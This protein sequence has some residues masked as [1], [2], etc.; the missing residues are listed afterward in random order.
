LRAE[1][2]RQRTE[3]EDLRRQ[4]RIL[5]ELVEE[6]GR[7]LPSP[8]PQRVSRRDVLK[9]GVVG[10]AAIAGAVVPSTGRSSAAG[11]QYL[12]V[13]A[14]V[15]TAHGPQN[16]AP[17]GFVVDPSAE[18]TTGV[19]AA[20]T[21][22]GVAGAAIDVKGQLGGGTGVQGQSQTGFGV[23]GTSTSA[24]GVFGSSQTK[25]GVHGSSQKSE[26]VFGQTLHG[27]RAVTG[28]NWGNAGDGVHG[29]SRQQKGRQ[30]GKGNGVFGQSGSGNGVVGKSGGGTGIRG[31]SGSGRGGVFQ[32][33]T[34]AVNL[35]PTKYSGHP[36]SGTH[37]KGDLMVDRNGD[38]YICSANGK[39]GRWK[40][41]VVK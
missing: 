20:G 35:Q 38:L 3:I 31:S 6:N 19:N 11:S 40:R 13:D 12:P 14:S 39:P 37:W 1:M 2:R 22:V 28:I 7:E 10:V 41:V 8:S 25:Y 21:Q 29:E 15:V 16:G 32:G 17:A 30:L 24:E 27:S 33:G 36:K 18:L 26:G 4:I 34:A 5:S 9:I 23:L